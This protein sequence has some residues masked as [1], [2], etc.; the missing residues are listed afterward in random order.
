MVKESEIIKE[1]DSR[2]PQRSKDGKQ[3]L[4]IYMDGE[5]VNFYVSLT[6]SITVS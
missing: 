5:R 2:W 4:E 6:L 3:E 1:D